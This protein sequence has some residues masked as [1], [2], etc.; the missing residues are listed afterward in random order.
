MPTLCTMHV[1]VTYKILYW[2]AVWSWSPLVKFDRKKIDADR[3]LPNSV[4]KRSLM[5]NIKISNWQPAANLHRCSIRRHW[6]SHLCIHCSPP[7]PIWLRLSSTLTT[8]NLQMI[9]RWTISM[10]GVGEGKPMVIINNATSMGFSLSSD[11]FAIFEDLRRG[12]KSIR[13]AVAAQGSRTNP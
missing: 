6:L 13:S 3:I 4:A 7:Q 9:L 11:D 5:K 2:K 12:I 8:L 10:Y 1:D